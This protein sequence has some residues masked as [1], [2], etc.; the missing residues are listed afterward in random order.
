VP[1]WMTS[2]PR[3]PLGA[4]Y[5][6]AGPSRNA[7]PVLTVGYRLPVGRRPVADPRRALGGP[8]P[9][10]GRYRSVGRRLNAFLPPPLTLKSAIPR[11]SSFFFIFN[12]RIGQQSAGICPPGRFGI[13]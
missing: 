10:V 1:R 11:Q 6:C 12:E 3:W 13:A 7:A 8:F 5:R 9:N 2:L 4:S